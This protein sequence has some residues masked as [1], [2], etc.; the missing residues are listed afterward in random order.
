MYYDVD[1][2]MSVYDK[3]LAFIHDLEIS[4]VIDNDILKDF[5]RFCPDLTTSISKIFSKRVRI[6]QRHFGG[7]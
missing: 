7:M 1:Y 6:W 4:P 2:S 5:E 3:D